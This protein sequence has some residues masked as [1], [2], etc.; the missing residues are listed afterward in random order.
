MG[1]SFHLPEKIYN[2]TITTQHLGTVPG[3]FEIEEP[4]YTVIKS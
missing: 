2:N 1:D 4:I 3:I